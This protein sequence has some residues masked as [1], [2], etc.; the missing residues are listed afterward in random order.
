MRKNRIEKVE[1][2][3]N[4]SRKHL[5]IKSIQ[6][7]REAGKRGQNFPQA[8]KNIEKTEKQVKNPTR[9]HLKI[10][11]IQKTREAGKKGA[12]FPAKREKI[13]KKPKK[14]VKKS[15]SQNE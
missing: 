5:K 7:T 10:K 4:Q 1:K 6:K 2:T 15:P 12:K 14:Q 9:K 8:G 11:S 3:K 13:S